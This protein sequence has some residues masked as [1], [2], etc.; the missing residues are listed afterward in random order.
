MPKV[1]FCPR[2]KLESF[3]QPLIRKFN[4]HFF[5]T[6]DFSRPCFSGV[7]GKDGIYFMQFEQIIL[8]ETDF[9]KISLLLKVARSEH[10]EFLEQELDRAAIVPDNEMPN[11]VVAMNSLV[12]YRDLDTGI[13]TSVLLV[14]PHEANV[15]KSFVSVLAPLGA[16]LIGLRSGQNIRWPLP[17]GREKNLQVLSIARPS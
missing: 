15:E 8:S 5:V 4:I 1:S 2:L 7:N 13:E 9:E 14:Y 16:A 11:D 10:S 12:R 6:F 17:N 3:F